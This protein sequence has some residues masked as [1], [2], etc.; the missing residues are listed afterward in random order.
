MKYEHV[1][2]ESCFLSEKPKAAIQPEDVEIQVELPVPLR[3]P[4]DTKKVTK[5]AKTAE[6]N[7]TV[8]TILQ[9][10]LCQSHLLSVQLNLRTFA[11]S[12][13]IY[14]MAHQNQIDYAALQLHGGQLYFS[15]DLGK[16]KAVAS[17]PAVVNDGKWHT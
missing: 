6:K 8:E 2:M 7:H 12:G 16:G 10:S 9:Y 4:T 3:P 5:G 13:L 1:D 15:F 11:S 17:H 14:Y